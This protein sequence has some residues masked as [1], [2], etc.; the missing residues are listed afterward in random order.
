MGCFWRVVGEVIALEACFERMKPGER[1]ATVR[2]GH[3]QQVIRVI[4]VFFHGAAVAGSH[5]ICQVPLPRWAHALLARRPGG[6]LGVVGG[7]NSADSQLRIPHRAPR[8]Q[9]RCSWDG[10][11]HG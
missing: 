11:S 3:Q 8:D 2:V 9:Q 6:E 7:P 1:I 4:Q 10:C 5:Q